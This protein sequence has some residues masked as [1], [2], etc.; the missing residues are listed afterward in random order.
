MKSGQLGS[1]ALGLCLIGAFCAAGDAADG[2]T[3]P[4]EQK[5]PVKLEARVIELELSNTRDILL[6]VQRA[7]NCTSSLYDEVNR[8]PMTMITIPNVVGP[9]VYSI[10]QPIPDTSQILP[11]RQKWVELYMGEIRPI[12]AYMKTDMDAIRNG[13]AALQFPPSIEQE[14]NPEIDT[15]GKDIDHA[16]TCMT[17]LEKLTAAP[18]YD[19]SAIAKETTELHQIMS[20]M[21]KTGKRVV[22]L[23]KQ[24]AKKEKKKEK[25]KGKNS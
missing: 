21:E 10:P 8:H 17:H 23:M 24:G 2:N 1:L 22:K 6:D 5:A 16:F 19:N 12:V 25:G 18:P 14:L 13:E 11:A 9:V 15:W 4:P 20:S 7:K 3:E